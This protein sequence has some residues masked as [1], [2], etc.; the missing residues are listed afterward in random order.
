M[1]TLFN[2]HFIL[3]FSFIYFSFFLDAL[4]ERRPCNYNVNKTHWG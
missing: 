1:T 4:T 3:F 2:E